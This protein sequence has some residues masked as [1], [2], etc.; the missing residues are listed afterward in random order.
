MQP[1]TVT[2]DHPDNL[3][4]PMIINRADF[5]PAIH[6][7]YD[8]PAPEPPKPEGDQKPPEGENKQPPAGDDKTKGKK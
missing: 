6:K 2:V 8:P 3:G 4:A 1:E 7:L 5:D